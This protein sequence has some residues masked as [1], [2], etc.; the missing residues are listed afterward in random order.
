MGPKCTY[1]KTQEA[2]SPQRDQKEL[3]ETVGV[4]NHS[5]C[6]NRIPYSHDCVPSRLIASLYLNG[7][8]VK[9]VFEKQALEHKH[10]VK[11]H[12]QSPVLYSAKAVKQSSTS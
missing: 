1:H 4:L 2:N 7:A 9:W 12:L 5:H 11:V 3:L 6:G 10:A 8:S